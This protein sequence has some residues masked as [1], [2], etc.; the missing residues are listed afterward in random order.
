MGLVIA[1][2]TRSEIIPYDSV[3][4]CED[5]TG[6]GQALEVYITE[7][8]ESISI[9]GDAN[10]DDFIE[11]YT[12]YLRLKQAIMG[13]VEEEEGAQGQIGPRKKGQ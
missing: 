2:I 10:I 11:G 7:R 3:I 6:K 1:Y 13:I 12:S 4:A 5:I 8:K 9:I